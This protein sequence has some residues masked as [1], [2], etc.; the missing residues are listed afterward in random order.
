MVI[1]VMLQFPG[2]V[3]VLLCHLLKRLKWFQLLQEL[4]QYSRN[5]GGARLRNLPIIT[6]IAF[7][8]LINLVP[9]NKQSGFQKL[10]I[11]NLP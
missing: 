1:L 4:N 5:V 6:R 8:I 2:E 10:L 11:R 3:L 9:I 7:P